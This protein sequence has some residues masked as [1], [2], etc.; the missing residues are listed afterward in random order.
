MVYLI[1]ARKSF[2]TNIAR[3]EAILLFSGARKINAKTILSQINGPE[4][5]DC[6]FV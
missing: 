2:L 3:K 4:V 1:I 5:N 6:F